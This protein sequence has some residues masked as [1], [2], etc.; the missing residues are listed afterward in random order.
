VQDADLAGHAVYREPDALNVECD[1]ARRQIGLALGLETVP[2]LA[3][4]GVKVRQRDLLV[5]ADHR[6]AIEAAGGGS[7]AGV[8]AGE[9]EDVVAH[10]AGC[11]RHRLAG[12]DGSGARE[13]AGI[14]GRQIG[15]GIDDGD[16][17]R[18]RG[19]D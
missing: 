8:A 17:A 2:G 1:G 15:V 19:E 7:D 4:G 9:I 13:R 10:G 14:K 11:Q 18:A 16:A 5:A 6:V 3:A 12:D